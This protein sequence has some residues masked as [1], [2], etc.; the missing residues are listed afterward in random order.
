MTMLSRMYLGNGKR[1]THLFCVATKHRAARLT[2]G[3]EGVARLVLAIRLVRR[4]CDLPRKLA[5]CKESFIVRLASGS[6]QASEDN[7]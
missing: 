2:A 5:D 4:R 7:D 3:H 1:E 6:R